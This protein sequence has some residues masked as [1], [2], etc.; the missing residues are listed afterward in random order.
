MGKE[1]NEETTTLN[2]SS[3]AHYIGEPILWQKTRQSA[4]LLKNYLTILVMTTME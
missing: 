2:S 1:I 3:E 4:G